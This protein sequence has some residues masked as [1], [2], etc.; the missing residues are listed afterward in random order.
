MLFWGLQRV[1]CRLAVG[2][3]R[4][5]MA[6]S[7]KDALQDHAIGLIVLGDE[8]AQ[9]PMWVGRQLTIIVGQRDHIAGHALSEVRVTCMALNSKVLS[10][11]AFRTA[12]NP[13]S[14]R[15]CAEP[16]AREASSSTSPVSWSTASARTPAANC[17]GSRSRSPA[18]TSTPL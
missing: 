14:R 5:P 1:Q 17:S 4:Y 9:S 13:A 12:E 10:N 3:D 8:D 18:T 7:F 2:H 16:S 15:D 6:R 11:G